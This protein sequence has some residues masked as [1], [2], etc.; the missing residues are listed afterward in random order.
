VLFSIQF[1]SSRKVAVT[2]LS[3]KAD[4]VACMLH[5]FEHV[6]IFIHR[7]ADGEPSESCGERICSNIEYPVSLMGFPELMKIRGK[8]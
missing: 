6:L 3:F 5:Y 8:V 7:V 2:S 4:A 1:G